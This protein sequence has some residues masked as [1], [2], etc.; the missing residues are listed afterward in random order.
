M[1]YHIFSHFISKQVND[2][3]LITLDSPVDDIKP[4]PLPRI[5]STQRY[6]NLI[7]VLRYQTYRNTTVNIQSFVKGFLAAK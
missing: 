6:F 7:F 5:G 3:A 1:F 2:I 4:I